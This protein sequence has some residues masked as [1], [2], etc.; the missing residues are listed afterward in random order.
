MVFRTHSLLPS[1]GTRCGPNLR[2]L[3]KLDVSGLQII[4]SFD[5]AFVSRAKCFEESGIRKV[6]VRQACQSRAGGTQFVSESI[7]LRLNLDELCLLLLRHS[8]SL[9]HQCF[10]WRICEPEFK[11]A[12]SGHTDTT[13]QGNFRRRQSQNQYLT[14]GDEVLGA[15]TRVPVVPGQPRS[16]TKGKAAP[17]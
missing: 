9:T 3:S 4:D 15:Y 1:T 8:Q 13:L 16:M 14:R 10:A 7:V 5:R 12:C 2:L 6:I 11:L 17:N